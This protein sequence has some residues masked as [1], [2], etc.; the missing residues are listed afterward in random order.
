MLQIPAF[1]VRQ[2]DLLVA[3]ART[4]KFINL[5][6][7]QFMS[8]EAMRFAVDKVVQS[9]ND[10]VLLTERDTAFGYQNLVVDLAGISIMKQYAPIVLDVT[11]ALQQPNS[12][13]G[14]TSRRPQLIETLAK[15]GIASGVD[16]IFLETHPESHK[17]KFDVTNM[18]KLDAPPELLEKLMPLHKAIHKHSYTP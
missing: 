15:A 10:R 14:I 1:L 18:L 17:A 5:K 12:H 7:A 11:H 13:S 6:K 4:G 9:G 3:A 8:P 16:G 2:T